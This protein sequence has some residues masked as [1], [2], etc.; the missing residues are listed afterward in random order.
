M[1]AGNVLNILMADDDLDDCHFFALALKTIAIPT[2]LVTLHDGEQLM[3]YLVKN[4]PKTPN[5][6]FL[7]I[8]MPRKNGFECLQEIK[9]NKDLNNFPVVMYSTSLKDTMVDML[10]QEGAHYYLRKCDYSDLVKHLRHILTMLQ[11]NN[12]KSPSQ[13]S[14]VLNDI[15]VF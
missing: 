11:D 10:F 9:N 5:I 15:R 7:D 6:L 13:S 4:K 3:N 8:N 12:L 1:T 14:F 2:K